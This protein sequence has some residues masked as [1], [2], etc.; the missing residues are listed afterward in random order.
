MRYVVRY[1]CCWSLVAHAIVLVCGAG[2][3]R[4]DLCVYITVRV[5]R[6]AAPFTLP[7]P[8]RFCALLPHVATLYVVDLLLRL[9]RFSRLFDLLRCTRRIISSS[10]VAGYCTYLYTVTHVRLRGWILCVTRLVT[11]LRCRTLRFISSLSFAVRAVLLSRSH[12]L[13]AV[14]RLRCVALPFTF[15]YLPHV[16]VTLRLV[17][18]R[19]ARSFCCAH[20]V[21]SFTAHPTHHPTVYAH[22][23]GWRLFL[24]RCRIY[25]L[26][27][28]YAPF[29]F[30]TLL[31]RISLPHAH[32]VRSLSRLLRFTRVRTVAGSLSRL[33]RICLV[34]DS[35]TRTLPFSLLDLICPHFGCARCCCCVAARCVARV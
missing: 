8:H 20:A 15:C 2:A 19:V 9:L 18:T 27:T 31:H 10:S 1:V 34:A 4:G 5:L 25:R 6:T 22:T 32:Y 7:A 21:G 3:L 26:Y 23:R 17:A 33:V 28:P 16:Y 14:T 11:P 30:V 24:L 13:H 12:L 35:R 29:G